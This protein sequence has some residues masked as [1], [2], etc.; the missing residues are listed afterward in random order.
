MSSRNLIWMET[1]WKY[2][3]INITILENNTNKMTMKEKR[4]LLLLARTVNINFKCI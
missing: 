2:R 4:W 1:Y 3:R